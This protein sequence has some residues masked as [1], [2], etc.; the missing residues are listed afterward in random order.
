ML[1]ALKSAVEKTGRYFAFVGEVVASGF[2][3]PVRVLRYVEEIEHIGVNSVPVIFLSGL[4]I[5]MIFALQMVSL[6]Q[7]FQAEIGTGAAVAVALAREFSPII[8]TL[9][10]IAKNGSAMAAE[11]GTMKVTE[12]IDALESMSV[13]PVQYLVLPRVVASVITFPCLT[14]LSNIVG[15]LGSYIISTTLYGIDAAS[16]SSYMFNVLKPIDIYIGLVKSSIMGFMV[17][18]ICCWYGL[19]VSQGAKG[20]GDG[21]TK[22]VVLS[23]VSILLGD[24]I[25]GSIVMMKIFQ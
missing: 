8:T 4:A 9:M 3:K 10:L 22:A 18:T 5:G 7:P 17:S 13:S 24:Y 2:R 15:V 14:M 6:L 20:V 23:S 11:L 12:Q 1:A 19:G 21:A 16:Y 25:M